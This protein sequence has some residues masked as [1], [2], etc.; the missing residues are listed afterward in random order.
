MHTLIIGLDAFDPVLFERLYNQGKMPVL[1]KYVQAGGYSPFTV[2]NPPQSEVSW[3]SIATGASPG[4]HGMFDFVHR[5]PGSYALSPSLLVTKGGF[6]G[7]QFVPPHT[8]R[9]LF[10]QV[11]IQGY[12]ATSLWWPATFPA[13]VELP[14]RT[15]PGLGTPD[16]Q[17][18]LGVGSVFT[19]DAEIAK[20]H[21]KTPVEMLAREGK[22]RYSGAIKGPKKDDSTN[23]TCSFSLEMLEDGA[24]LRLGKQTLILEVGV[25]SPIIEVP[26]KINALF[27]MRAITRVI[28]TQ[29]EP[30]PRLYFL[31]VQ[32]HPLNSPWRYATPPGFV[33]QT[34]NN[35]GPFLTLGW[36][37]DTTGLEEGWINDGQFLDLCASI[38]E[39]RERVLNYHLQ[40]FREGVLAC[41]FDTLDRVQHMFW[42][43][44]PDLIESWYTRLD[45]LV[46]RIEEQ[47][48]KNK[49][50]TAKVIVVSDHGFGNLD[51]KVHLNHWLIERGYLETNSP[52]ERSLRG[53]DWSS[54]SAYAVG[55]NSLYLNL[56][57]REAQG[58]VHEEQKTNLIQRLRDD[59]LA[60]VGPD[61][62]RVV[63]EVYDQT[64]SDEPLAAYGP[65]L[66]IGYTPG[67]RASAETGLGQWKGSSLEAN[68]D[69]WG[70]DHCF[71]PALVPGVLFCSQGLDFTHQPSYRDFPELATGWAIEINHSS[72]PPSGHDEDQDLV[73]ERLK[74]L[75]YL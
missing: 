7:T 19:E 46:G 52:E 41:V 58:C 61:G 32:I 23:L 24:A 29:A 10:E 70:A 37:Q 6:G 68:R 17:G 27:S 40:N 18:R 9:T 57:G 45:A 66:L 54:S 59:L 62:R 72:T 64:G 74:S 11:T 21:L 47:L 50:G 28:L 4:S 73:E 14:V 12:P 56:Q 26:F 39:S 3:T 36:P 42:K 8:A 13:R 44:H 63:N 55:L 51:Y 16:I 69:H 67:Y 71:D 33:K 5:S 34:W 35:A 20:E 30:E 65:D 15:L 31:P 38:I 22:G 49:A 1:G 75:G 60:W 53:A 48:V 25:W 2:S 43:T